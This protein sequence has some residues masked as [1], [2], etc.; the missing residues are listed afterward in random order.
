MAESSQ[1]LQALFQRHIEQELAALPSRSA[2]HRDAF[3]KCLQKFAKTGDRCLRQLRER[4]IQ[5][6]SQLL[7]SLPMLPRK[8][9]DFGISLLQALKAK[10]AVPVLVRMLVDDVEGR[11]S[12]G[13]ASYAIGGKQ[14]E[15]S[16]VQIAR[17]ELNPAVPNRF[18][19]EAVIHGLKF[20]NSDDVNDVLVTIFER[21]D[22]AGWLRGDAGD[23]IHVADRRTRLFHRTW[24]AALRGLTES[25]IDVQFRSMFAIA[26]LTAINRIGQRICNA[27]FHAALPRAHDA[28]CAR[29]NNPQRQRGNEHES[30][31]KLKVCGAHSHAHAA[32]YLAPAGTAVDRR[33]AHSLAD[34]AGYIPQS[35]SASCARSPSSAK[36][37]LMITDW[38]PDSG[39]QCLPKRKTRLPAS[40]RGPAWTL[41]RR[42][43][44]LATKNTAR[45]F[46]TEA[47]HAVQPALTMSRTARHRRCSTASVACPT[48]SAGAGCCAVVRNASSI[49]ACKTVWFRRTTCRPPASRSASF[50]AGIPAV[51]IFCL[52]MGMSVS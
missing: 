39:G 4:H 32:G 26:R 47:S 20:S 9:K 6:L 5:T 12:C 42:S 33:G 31:I 2:E 51:P 25:D 21:T 27:R 8:L 28:L 44:G 22:L 48:I 43:A 15:K 18:V 38:L 36:L 49:S 30:Q 19:L 29:Q 40:K 50:G 1:N 34:A 46:E 14:T 41:K 24:V 35:Q 45:G 17:R 3:V 13:C 10:Q 11:F 16:L 37:P 7:E 52:S 23:A